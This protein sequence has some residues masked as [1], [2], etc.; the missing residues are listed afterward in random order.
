[1]K[2]NITKVLPVAAAVLLFLVWKCPFEAVTGIPCPGCM[3]TT[4]AYYL[5][6]FDFEKA[7]YFNPVIFLLLFMSVPLMI[8][9]KKNKKIFQKLLSATLIIWL[10]V[11]AYRMA[12]IFPDFPM[13]YVE[14]NLILNLL[15]RIK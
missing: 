13:S 2:R 7:F 9:Y 8:A 1:M 15:K 14:D 3:M 6:H 10:C 11:Y 4:A 5:I 12:V